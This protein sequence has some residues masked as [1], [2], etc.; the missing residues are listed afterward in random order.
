MPRVHRTWVAARWCDRLGVLR[1]VMLTD[2]MKQGK[3]RF[4]ANTRHTASTRDQQP[5]CGYEQEP[6]NDEIDRVNM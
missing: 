5:M 6:Q 1:G 3:R 2:L 4:V